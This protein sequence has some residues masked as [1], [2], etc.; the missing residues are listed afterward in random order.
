MATSIQET[1]QKLPLGA[2]GKGRR[3]RAEN[4]VIRSRIESA[5]LGG[6]DGTREV[7]VFITGNFFFSVFARVLEVFARV[8]VVLLVFFYFF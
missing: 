7:F 1:A 3:R 8:L 6:S 5:H 2:G 4:D